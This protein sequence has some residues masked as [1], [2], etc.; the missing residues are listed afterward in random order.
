MGLT[1]TTRSPSLKVGMFVLSK[2]FVELPPVTLP[3]PLITEP[4]TFPGESVMGRSN[5]PL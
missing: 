5:F 1:W 3:F 4:T 2:F